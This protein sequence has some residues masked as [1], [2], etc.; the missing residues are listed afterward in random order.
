MCRRRLL[1]S[2]FYI[3]YG[4]TKKAHGETVIVSPFVAGSDSDTFELYARNPWA[5][6][7]NLSWLTV[8]SL[9]NKS[10]KYTITITAAENQAYSERS[11]SFTAKTLD[12]R[13]SIVVSVSQQAKP[14]VRYIE[15]VPATASISSLGTTSFTCILHDNGTETDVTSLVEWSSS[16]T[17]AATISNGTA[18]GRNNTKTEK[19]V[20]ITA[21]YDGLS[22]TA[23][24]NVA[25]GA[26]SWRNY[27][28][29]IEASESTRNTP[30][31]LDA[32]N[33]TN[34]VG[35]GA[36][37]DEYVN[38]VNFQ[39]WAFTEGSD[40]SIGDD[41]IARLE[42]ISEGARHVFS[43]Y[44]DG[45]FYPDQRTTE[46]TATTTRGTQTFT[47]TKIVN[48]APQG[49]VTHYISVE[50][51]TATIG[52]T[53]E[54]QL[55]VLYHTVTDGV[56]DDGVDVTTSA[57]YTDN[58]SNLIDVNA[59]G[60]V[61]GSGSETGGN[62]VVTVSYPGVE[63][64]DVPITVRDATVDYRNFR[65][66]PLSMTLGKDDVTA[67]KQIQA[68]VD[69]FVNNVFSEE[70][71]VTADANW[72]SQNTNVASVS[73]SG[74]N[75]VVK[76]VYGAGYFPTT[77]TTQ[78]QASYLGSAATCDV[79][80]EPEGR[81]EHIIV[82]TPA[83]VN[84]GAVDE[85]QLSV[86]YYEVVD[87]VTAQT[88]TDITNSATY[89][90]ETDMISISNG[91][92]ITSN[93][94]GESPANATITVNYGDAPQVNVP[95]VAA[96]RT[97]E[98]YLVIT[99][100]TTSTTWNGEVEYEVYYV[101]EIN[102]QEADRVKI[103]NPDHVQFTLSN[104]TAGQMDDF[105]FKAENISTSNKTVNITAI[106][107][108]GT[109]SGIM[110]KTPATLTVNGADSV[111]YR[112]DVEA[113]PTSIAYSGSS[114]LYASAVTVVN[115]SVY[116]WYVPDDVVWSE[117]STAITISND[118]VTGTH[119][120]TSST[121]AVI[122]GSSESFGENG[123]VTIAIG[124]RPAARLTIDRDSTST[125][126]SAAGQCNYYVSWAYLK[127][128]TT[129]A[130][131]TD[132]L[133][134]FSPTSITIT[135]SNYISGNREIV[136]GQ[137]TE[138]P[139][140]SQRNLS[141]SGVAQ[142]YY[143]GTAR[144]YHYYTQEE[145]ETPAIIT[146][147]NLRFKEVYGSTDRD[148]SYT[149][150]SSAGTDWAYFAYEDVMTNGT[151]TG[152]RNASTICTYQLKS[153]STTIATFNGG[154]GTK[155][156]GDY[157]TISYSTNS[158]FTFRAHNDDTEPKSYVLYAQDG[159]LSAS[160]E[161][162]IEEGEA[163][164]PTIS[165]GG[166]TYRV[167]KSG[168][169]NVDSVRFQTLTVGVGSST[170][171]GAERTFENVSTGTSSS[172]ST[173]SSTSFVG[174]VGETIKATLHLYLDPTG[175]SIDGDVTLQAAQ[176]TFTGTQV[177]HSADYYV[178][179]FNI[180]TVPSASV[181]LG[182]FTVSV[183]IGLDTA[184]LNIS[185]EGSHNYSHD[186][187]AI[188]GQSFP[189]TWA[190][191]NVS[192]IAVSNYTGN[193]TGATIAGTT[194]KYLVVNA[195]A[196]ESTTSTATSV[197][198]IT[199]TSLNDGTVVSAELIIE[200]S[201]AEPLPAGVIT[202]ND[203]GGSIKASG[204][205]DDNVYL[206][207]TNLST[208]HPIT[209]DC[210][211]FDLDN[212]TTSYTITSTTGTKDADWFNDRFTLTENQSTN[213]RTIIITASGV[214]L[215]GE[216]VTATIASL[217]QAGGSSLVPKV[218]V[219]QGE[220]SMILVN[221]YPTSVTL[222]QFSVGLGSPS[223]LDYGFNANGSGSYAT[224]TTNTVSGTRNATT[225]KSQYYINAEWRPTTATTVQK[226]SI[227]RWKENGVQ[228]EETI[229]SWNPSIPT[230]TVTV[231]TVLT[232]FELIV[233]TQNVATV[234]YN[235]APITVS[236]RANK[237]IIR[238][239][240]G[241]IT[242]TDNATA[243]NK[244]YVFPNMTSTI[245]NRETVQLGPSSVPTSIST[246]S[247]SITVTLNSVRFEFDTNKDVPTR[248]NLYYD[249]YNSGSRQTIRLS[250]DRSGVFTSDTPLVIGYVGAGESYGLLGAANFILEITD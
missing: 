140:T 221:N 12:D 58:G 48:V 165:V 61:N 112:L 176:Q 229:N 51:T 241:R 128:G 45:A 60:K 205:F 177:S 87:G 123:T 147:E 89:G 98:E 28:I 42:K 82:V 8:S 36:Y 216:L 239:T 171:A 76:P 63:S 240:S 129:I 209:F 102:G 157:L 69:V 46:I 248:V 138:N 198:T 40:W 86:T 244:N 151:K 163:P 92:K 47:A 178:Y 101:I 66:I 119:T 191:V 71:E 232:D 5:I 52:S 26:V 207:W 184:W 208:A 85:R 68:Y 141:L 39:T 111:D 224:G 249:N 134:N 73:K 6:T 84:M 21:E 127:P 206:D 122:T 202:W 91:G 154:T 218:Y 109:Y 220:D 159:D 169:K 25:A 150:L 53:G 174:N 95:V 148:K 43:V 196:N 77:R 158:G 64:V 44:N 37:I 49:L 160:F 2:N 83:S 75:E 121:S 194:T 19:Q 188:N 247:G 106:C 124:G 190:N 27:R 125:V 242:F 168:N 54:V 246:Q 143:D 55:T 225:G 234:S 139:N 117:N 136:V 103:T 108:G 72:S 245:G 33:I 236:N 204:K 97:T 56:D 29:L 135:E 217:K 79:T 230:R 18:T 167:V 132:N 212:T 197:I 164:M 238:V 81:I 88:G 22:A 228:Q 187:S 110:T 180:G 7:N 74:T 166:L 214:G 201:K 9:S 153:G 183:P 186:A 213:Q 152:E 223:S 235:Y 15:I 237:S 57:E 32:T 94:T 250:G 10:G 14:S 99:P 222:N 96:S 120:G 189:V 193:V 170:V 219:G 65:V 50:P 80:V 34:G 227:I 1:K 231:D 149:S 172:S 70:L 62:A 145:K 3:N 41:S 161:I 162:D 233:K 226:T 105:T 137:Y 11:G 23:T 144:D 181:S 210:A 192:S 78:V 185:G 199:G 35:V 107:T 16:D 243:G 155:Y 13:F 113:V 195:K 175:T 17:N 115:G 104:N 59:T 133:S 90:G 156:D 30:V 182:N 31:N 114:Q 211:Y 20:T 4:G 131:T 67:G 215:D 38:E 93:N 118:T 24:L 173:W 142:T 200:Q 100:A 116:K 130:L 179:E 203:M 126:S 146:Y